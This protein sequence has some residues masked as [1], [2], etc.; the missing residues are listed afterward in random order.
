MKLVSLFAVLLLSGCASI[1]SIIPSFHD[2]NESH[3]SITIRFAISELDCTQPHQ[4]Q[5][6]K[7]DRAVQ[8]MALYTESKG[9]NDIAEM[10]QPMKATVN[11]F[12]KKGNEGSETYCKIKK[13]LLEK[14]SKEIAETVMGRF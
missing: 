9:S 4:P 2:D 12:L 11:D 13:S 1:Q 7:I 8:Y 6:A 3:L 10:M 14:Q 5:V